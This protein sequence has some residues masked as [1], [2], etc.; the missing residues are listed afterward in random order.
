MNIATVFRTGS[1]KSALLPVLWVVFLQMFCMPEFLAAQEKPLVGVVSYPVW[2][3]RGG[4]GIWDE[5]SL[6]P[7]K[8]S[9]RLPFFADVTNDSSRLTRTSNTKQEFVYHTDYDINHV[10]LFTAFNDVETCNPATDIE[11]STSPDN[12]TYTNKT[13]TFRKISQT[14]DWIKVTFFSS[15]STAGTRYIKIALSKTDGTA[16]NPQIMRVD[17]NYKVDSTDHPFKSVFTDNLNDFT[18]IYSHSTDLIL[19]SDNPSQYR[20]VTGMEYSQEHV[21]RQIQYAVAH[22]IDYFALLNSFP[23]SCLQVFVDLLRS[24]SYKNDVKYCLIVFAPRGGETWTDKVTRCVEYFRDSNYVKVLNGRPLVYLY[25]QSQSTVEE[26]NQLCSTSVAFDAGDPYLVGLQG[27][28]AAFLDAGSYY[29]TTSVGVLQ[30]YAGTSNTIPFVSF[31][32]HTLPREDNP[33]SWGN[34]YAA[35]M[36]MS[37]VQMAPY[38]IQALNWCVQH[39]ASVPANAILINAWDEFCESSSSLCPSRNPATGLPDTSRVEAIG[40]AIASW[41]TDSGSINMVLN[42]DFSSISQWIFYQENGASASFSLDNG[43]GRVAITNGAVN[44]WDI[45]L[46]QLG[47]Y[48][49]PGKTYRV[50]FKAKSSA[51]RT[52]QGSIHLQNNPW[53]SIWSQ[54]VN[55]DSTQQTFG[56]FTFVFNGSGTSEYRINF[57]PGGNNNSVWIDDVEVYEVFQTHIKMSEIGMNSLISVFPNPFNPSTRIS[58]ELPQPQIVELAI[59]DMSGRRVRLLVSQAEKAGMHSVEWNGCDQQ[60]RL[61]GSGVYLIKLKTGNKEMVRRAVLIK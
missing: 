60:E 21:D 44:T 24:S 31:G 46:Y 7:P 11:V 55:L 38:V 30:N 22:H 27:A 42:S 57:M 43:M 50:N 49:S 23:T 36:E 61:M 48:F 51:P 40:N 9:Y 16:S 20:L 56:E 58:Y 33:P 54:T 1:K 47:L 14:A 4:G 2:G 18:K 37:G 25:D 29:N 32:D 41:P 28:S 34:F 5:I 53:T 45:Q 8:W 12:I 17:I 13:M 39:S 3:A 10:V 6:T 15:I 19:A 35:S 59:F 52:L 26:I